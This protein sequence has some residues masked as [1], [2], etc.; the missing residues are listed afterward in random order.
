MFFTYIAISDNKETLENLQI[1]TKSNIANAYQNLI[2]LQLLF[3]NIFCRF[4]ILVEF[5]LVS[6]IGDTILERVF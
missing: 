3:T 2:L 4:K 5:F 6:I 1:K